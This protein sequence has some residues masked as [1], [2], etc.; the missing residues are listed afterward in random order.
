MSESQSSGLPKPPVSLSAV[1]AC[2]P[3]AKL[4][5]NGD[6]VVADLAHP[7]MITGPDQMVLILDA[8]ALVLLPHSPFPVKSAVVAEGIEVPEGLLE[9]YIS[10]ER[11][12]LA[13]ATLLAIFE[14][15]VHAVAGIH[16]TAVIESSAKVHPSV[17]VGAFVYVGEQALI[18][19]NT[20]LM[21]HVTV[22]AEVKMGANCLLHSGVRIG[23]RVMMGNRVVIQ[24]NASI[25]ADGFSYVTPEPS[26]VESA[27]S[28]GGKVTGQN[29]QIFKINS[30]GT[31]VLE[32]DVEVGACATID[33][34]NLGATL[35]KKGTKIDN[36][37]MIAHN[38]VIG[39]NCLI[40]SQVGIAGSCEIGNRVVAA[41]QVGVADH[42]KVG[43][44]SILMAKAGIIRDIGPKSVVMGYPALPRREAFQNYMYTGKLRE[45]FQDFK[46]LKK[47]VAELESERKNPVEV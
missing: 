44:D 21:P 34:S 40:A 6:L 26:S 3:G 7:R 11:P 12:R 14:K 4:H 18:G 46:A 35:I 37:V 22:G 43:D 8:A 41:G 32:D 39:E 42:M 47:R 24:H 19:A 25:G 45:L 2:T 10:V 13:L 31:V 15:P 20:I 36:L 5:G 17:S 27:Q 16:P 23:E 33:R 28:S 38:N 9:A 1:A 30:I 29:S